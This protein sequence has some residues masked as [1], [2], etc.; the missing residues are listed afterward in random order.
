MTVLGRSE[1][2]RTEDKRYVLSPSNGFFR[3]GGGGKKSDGS[4][5]REEL[6][7]ELEK[8]SREQ[9]LKDIFPYS[10]K[11][12]RRGHEETSIR[13]KK[14]CFYESFKQAFPRSVGRSSNDAL[15]HLPGVRQG[16]D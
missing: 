7:G 11:F 10:M 6:G 5:G 4:I 2:W 3:G 12:P 16:E 8:V 14:N 1:E 9:Q 13:K 15:E